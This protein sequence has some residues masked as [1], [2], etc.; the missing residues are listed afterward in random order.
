MMGADYTINKALMDRVEEVA[1]YGL[2][3]K[4]YVMINIHWDGGWIHKFSTDYD[5]NHE[6]VQDNLEPDRRSLQGLR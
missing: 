4:M 1:K 2:D 3:N 5:R 6:K